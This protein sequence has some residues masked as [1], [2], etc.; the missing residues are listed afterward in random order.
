[1]RNRLRLVLTAIV[2]ILVVAGL[3]RLVGGPGVLTDL[4]RVGPLG[5]LVVALAW[6][7]LVLA[8]TLRWRTSIVATAKR[9][10]FELVLLRGLGNALNAFLPARA[11]DLARVELL[12]RRA[13]V[14]R[15]AIAGLELVDV[16]VDKL[17][18]LPAMAVVSALD[19]P[20][21]W[22]VRLVPWI[23]L[24][25]GL[26]AVALVVI[27]RWSRAP[28]WIEPLRVA[29]A[30]QGARAIAARALLVGPLPWLVET[31]GIA[32]AAHAVG[33]PLSLSG[34]FAALTAM[35]IAF[36][37]P[38]PSNAGAV[39]VGLTGAMTALGFESG[40]AIA[41]AVAYH[42]GQLVPMVVVG[43]GAAFW[44]RDDRVKLTGVAIDSTEPAE[45][46]ETPT[47]EPPARRREIG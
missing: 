39:E 13:G 31:A 46:R 36:A 6:V 17:G 29:V 26:A 30:S 33:I 40:P 22:I 47:A 4:A 18:W 5:P 8:Q 12:A 9:P 42:V 41:F 23:A 24:L 21:P 27:G 16:V 28:R 2:S 19:R 32:V 43:L 34:S 37:I 20:A 11:G 3:L 10:F 1:M 38:V 35:N 44:L 14:D 25:G 7:P 45:P 15:R